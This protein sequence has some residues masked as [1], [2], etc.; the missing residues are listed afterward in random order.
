[1]KP[2]YRKDG[3][4]IYHGDCHEVLEFLLDRRETA[5][6]FATDPPFGIN[7]R[8]DYTR[9]P[10]KRIEGDARR[11]SYGE[12]SRLAFQMLKED[13]ALF[14]FTGWSE[15]PHH[16]KQVRSAG[17][18]MKE[19]II[20]QKR[21]SG[22]TDLYGSFQSNSDWII[23]AH[24]GRFKFRPTKLLKNKS[25]GTIPNKGRKP[26]SEFKTRFPSCWFGDSFPWSTE[27]PSSVSHIRHPS[28]KSVELMKWLI[29]LSTDERD[30]VVDPFLGSGSTLLAASL[31]NRKGIGIES[32]E[33]YCEIAAGRLDRKI[34]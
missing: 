10:H 17:F 27:N 11:F 25:A 4:T 22:T 18:S 28:I 29:R 26:V 6:V 2:Y 34:Q 24:K 31:L 30:M 12:W 19:P 16:F 20:A 33:E 13:S 3:V 1:M 14:A 9:N 7:Y 15:Y 5:D 23:F 32:E 21:P 8:N